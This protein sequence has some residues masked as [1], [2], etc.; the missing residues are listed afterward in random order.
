MPM[1]LAPRIKLRRASRTPRRALPILPDGHLYAA[2]PAENRL[3]VP[4]RAR[5]NHKVMSRQGHMAIL[6]S[7]VEPAA[8]R[9]DRYNVQRRAVMHTPRLRIHLKP[10]HPRPLLGIH[11]TV[12]QQDSD[13]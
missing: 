8:P 3:L 6:A 11:K 5:P 12:C 13:R 7:I 9:L 10:T 4:L 1:A 2:S